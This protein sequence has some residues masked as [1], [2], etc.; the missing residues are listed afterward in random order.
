MFHENRGSTGQAES[1]LQGELV[2]VAFASAWHATDSDKE[3]CR[4]DVGC[5]HVL[6]VHVG[7]PLNPQTIVGPDEPRDL[8]KKLFP[9]VTWQLREGCG[10]NWPAL[11]DP[12]S[13]LA[14]EMYIFHLA[15]KLSMQPAVAWMREAHGFFF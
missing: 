6:S 9:R 4:R 1:D 3:N 8:T 10:L 14:S 5:L 2:E 11:E 7:F 13:S 12:S 15:E